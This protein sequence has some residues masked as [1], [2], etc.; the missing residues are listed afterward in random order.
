MSVN[1]SQSKHPQEI[2]ENNSENLINPNDINTEENKEENP[3]NLSQQ[4][5]NENNNKN[6][7]DEKV[8][9]RQINIFR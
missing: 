8:E 1:S 5:N 6:K 3:N 2:S 4:S 9:Q 7:N